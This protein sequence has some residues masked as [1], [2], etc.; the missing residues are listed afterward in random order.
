MQSSLTASLSK[1]SLSRKSIGL[2]ASKSSLLEIGLDKPL[3]R[4]LLEDIPYS[5]DL[6]V[7]QPLEDKIKIIQRDL[8]RLSFIF[9]QVYE[10]RFRTKQ[11]N[12]SLS[13]LLR[14][15]YDGN[16]AQYLDHAA[17]QAWVLAHGFCD[18]LCYV[19]EH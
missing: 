6:V 19:T 4:L 17:G 13:G 18:R 11:L 7:L 10:F 9:E 8:N 1:N 5:F 3:H 12:E 14:V 2:S 15:V 16:F